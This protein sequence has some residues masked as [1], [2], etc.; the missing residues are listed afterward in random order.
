MLNILFDVAKTV[1]IRG[2]AFEQTLR[3]I[4]KQ[5]NEGLGG[6]EEV[7]LFALNWV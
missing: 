3:V 1:C 2:D 4:R 5:F 6:V 7:S